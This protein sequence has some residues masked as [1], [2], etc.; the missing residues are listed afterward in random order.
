MVGLSKAL[1]VEAARHGVRVSVLC[2]GFINTPILTGGKYGK[3]IDQL[4]K[5]Q[6]ARLLERMR[7]M[8]PAEFARKTIDAVAKNRF[9]II[10]PSWWRAVWM[11]QRAAPDLAIYLS[12]RAIE[13]A[14]R[15]VGL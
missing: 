4:P 12:R 11:I 3:M 1:K 2:P 7:A 5:E 15:E 9:V 10:Q 13:K 8:E 14:L 6:E